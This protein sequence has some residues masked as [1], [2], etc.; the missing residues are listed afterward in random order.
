VLTKSLFLGV[1]IELVRLQ[2]QKTGEF[3]KK[4][5]TEPQVSFSYERKTKKQIFLK[6]T[7]DGRIYCNESV[8]EIIVEAMQTTGRVLLT[9]Q[10]LDMVENTL[11]ELTTDLSSVD[12]FEGADLE[13]ILTE[14]VVKAQ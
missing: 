2:G 11:M 1:K 3:Y 7:I 6:I 14:A 10:F 12:D 4:Q 13:E 8:T 5:R 9:D